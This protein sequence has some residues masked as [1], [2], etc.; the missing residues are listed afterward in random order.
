MCWETKSLTVSRLLFPP[1]YTLSE[2]FYS[3]IVLCTG[4]E[5]RPLKKTW[6]KE[7]DKDKEPQRLELKSL[8]AFLRENLS[9]SDR[10]VM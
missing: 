2:Q 6:H 3:Y 10:F 4:L 5:E 9:N 8:N 1:P 7:P